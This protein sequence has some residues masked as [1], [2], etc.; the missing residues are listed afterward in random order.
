MRTVDRAEIRAGVEIALAEAEQARAEY[1]AWMAVW[2]T[3]N[4]HHGPFDRDT[5]LPEKFNR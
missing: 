2:R 1:D 4:G 3:R 5:G